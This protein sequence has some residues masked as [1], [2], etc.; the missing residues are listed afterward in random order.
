MTISH[1][2]PPP[3]SPPRPLVSKTFWWTFDSGESKSILAASQ[4]NRKY[5]LQ[6]DATKHPEKE[7]D[8]DDDGDEENDD[9]DNDDA[10]DD[11]DDNDDVDVIF[12]HARQLP[13]FFDAKSSQNGSSSD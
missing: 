6:L 4:A 9:D 2:P 7:D 13:P 12:R 3:S 8:D 10:E 1:P 11:D 5:A